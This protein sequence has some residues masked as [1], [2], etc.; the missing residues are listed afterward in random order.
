[1]HQTAQTLKKNMEKFDPSKGLPAVQPT[2]P[3][4][5][6][7]SEDE[8]QEVRKNVWSQIVSWENDEARSVVLGG[9]ES[10]VVSRRRLCLPVY[11]PMVLPE[12]E[13]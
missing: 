13:I 1:M 10:R 5:G 7:K 11:C 3:E 9:M 2:K 6:W 8:R 4:G 12:F